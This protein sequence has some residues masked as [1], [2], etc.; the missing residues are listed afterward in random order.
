VVFN[1]R[2]L[3]ISHARRSSVTIQNAMSALQPLQQLSTLAFVITSMASV[4]LT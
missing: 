4:G 2:F 3:L 1:L